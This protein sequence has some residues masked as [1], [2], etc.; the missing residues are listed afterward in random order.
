MEVGNPVFSNTGRRWEKLRET[1][2]GMKVEIL[3]KRSFFEK[4]TCPCNATGM[5][6]KT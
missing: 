3:Y 6:Q 1:T 4:G 2:K 5:Q